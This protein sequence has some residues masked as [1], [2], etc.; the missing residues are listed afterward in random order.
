MATPHVSAVLALI[1]SAQ[2]ALR[3][4]PDRLVAALK[5]GARSARN[6]TQVLSATDKSKGDLTGVACGKGY[7]HL[8]GATISN[9]DAYGAGIV[10]APQPSSGG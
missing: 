1:A 7:C 5:A 3:G 8:G 2:P 6:L 4:K 10:V 9:S